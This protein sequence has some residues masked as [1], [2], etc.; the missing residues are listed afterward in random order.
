MTKC[1]SLRE[2]NRLLT[3]KVEAEKDMAQLYKDL[4]Q[5]QCWVYDYRNKFNVKNMELDSVRAELELMT[6]KY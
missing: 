5:Q 4:N 2:N 1:T 3:E 6:R